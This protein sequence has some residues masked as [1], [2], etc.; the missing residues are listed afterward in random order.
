M[1]P[2]SRR[3]DAGRWPR[4]S[5]TF[6]AV[7]LLTALL[8]L[9][10]GKCGSERGRTRLLETCA[11]QMTLRCGS[12]GG[13][14]QQPR[15]T[16]RSRSV[17]FRKRAYGRA[18]PSLPHPPS[19]LLHTVRECVSFFLGFDTGPRV[20]SGSFALLRAH[21]DTSIPR[22]GLGGGGRCQTGLRGET[23]KH[24]SAFVLREGFRVEAIKGRTRSPSRLGEPRA[25]ASGNLGFGESFSLPRCLVLL[26]YPWHTRAV[27][28]SE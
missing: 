25:T 10:C 15:L 12:G 1:A 3:K 26:L 9:F 18:P 4:M 16:H 11:R 13:T 28:P 17:N 21:N 5:S 14:A 19:F 2:V 24:L 22:A 27:S 7:V 20:C 6:W 8:L 23:V